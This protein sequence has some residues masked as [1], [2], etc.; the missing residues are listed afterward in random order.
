VECLVI[1]GGPA[2]LA[3]A[4]YLARFRRTV[5]VVDAG[6]SRAAWI[7]VSNNILGFP[8]GLSGSDLLTRLREQAAEYGAT[9]VAG[10]VSGLTQRSDGSFDAAL[11]GRSINAARVLL[12]T[13]GLDVEPELPGLRDAVARGLVRYCPICDAYEV[14]GRKVALI[15]FGKCRVNEALLLRRYTEHLTV[16][17]LGQDMEISEDDEHTL[18]E[19]GIKVL[20]TPVTSLRVEGDTIAAWHM[21]DGTQHCFDTIYSA[22][23]TRIRSSLATDLGA[24]AD[25]DGALIVDRHQQTSVAG[26]YA[27]GD[28][29]AG[30]SQISVASGHAA[31]AATHLNAGLPFTPARTLD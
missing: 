4:V 28:V 26:L 6:A 24:T 7:P 11:D 22:L 29:V 17:T 21:D 1:G 25:E 18:S 8:H 27:A 14:S 15:A 19:A 9:L 31:I 20:R 12:A 13:G 5:T 3:A 2:G 10:E 23:G 16:L 30:L